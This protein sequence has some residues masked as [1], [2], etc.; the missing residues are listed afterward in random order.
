[1]P[2]AVIAA[3]AYALIPPNLST[4]LVFLVAGCGIA[5]SSVQRGR[6]IGITL[7][8]CSAGVVLGMGSRAAV[9]SSQQQAPAL[10][11]AQIGRLWG[12][13]V[14][15]SERTE[16]GWQIA[17]RVNEIGMNNV[18]TSADLSVTLSARRASLPANATVPA[19]GSPL[20][21]SIAGLHAGRGG[22][23]YASAV[24]VFVGEPPT[25]GRV[26]SGIYRALNEIIRAADISPPVIAEGIAVWFHTTLFGLC[27]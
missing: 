26:R 20:Q 13:V 6:L 27:V 21:A 22:T 19:P 14:G 25:A 23:W 3:A 9:A 15:H 7:L 11:A 4:I 18:R 8:V 16:D 24:E 1:M 17:V 12:V 5:L 10:P 2:A